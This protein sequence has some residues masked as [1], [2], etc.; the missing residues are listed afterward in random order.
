MQIE[1]MTSIN[2]VV[3]CAKQTGLQSTTIALTRQKVLTRNPTS[4]CPVKAQNNKA[5]LMPGLLV[6]QPQK[7]LSSH[8]QAQIMINTL[9]PK[10]TALCIAIV[11]FWRGLPKACL[12]FLQSA[13][14]L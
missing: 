9:C 14:M 7:Q 8:S 2:V 5:S 6:F 13:F 1:S 11:C 4:L 3:C 12:P 10:L